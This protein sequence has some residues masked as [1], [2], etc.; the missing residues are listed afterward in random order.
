M[1]KKQILWYI[2]AIYLFGFISKSL[3]II[4]FFSYLHFRRF[5]ESV[6]F[7]I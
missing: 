3:L 4:V 1:I 6:L 7:G 2:L 5:V